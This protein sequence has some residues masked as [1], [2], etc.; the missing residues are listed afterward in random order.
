MARQTWSSTLMAAFPPEGAPL[1]SALLALELSSD[2]LS[3]SEEVGAG[4][5]AFQAVA[6]TATAPATLAT[7]FMRSGYDKL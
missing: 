5:T 6:C 1:S 7:T 4:I 2:D 3:S